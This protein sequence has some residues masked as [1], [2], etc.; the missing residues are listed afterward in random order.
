MDDVGETLPDAVLETDEVLTAS[1][2]EAVRVDAAKGEN[3]GGDDEVPA[4]LM[5]E[6]LE[7][8]RLVVDDEAAA[9][10]EVVFELVTLVALLC[11]VTWE[12]DSEALL[13]FTV[14]FTVALEVALVDFEP[15]AAGFGLFLLLPRIALRA[16]RNSGVSSS[17]IDSWV[18]ERQIQ[19]PK[20]ATS[21]VVRRILM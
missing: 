21:R 1:E 14:A 17:T 19:S 8:L 12:A 5:L 3:D 15:P 11:V 10:K 4:T 2:A 9:R 16:S 13:E 18:R 7:E 20:R 6:L